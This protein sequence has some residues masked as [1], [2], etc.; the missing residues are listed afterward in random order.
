MTNCLSHTRLIFSLEIPTCKWK[1]SHI[2]IKQDNKT[3]HK[4]EQKYVPHTWSSPFSYVSKWF[5]KPE[6]VFVF[7]LIS[8][9]WYGER[10]WNLPRI[11]ATL[12]PAWLEN[13]LR[14]LIYHL[15]SIVTLYSG[16]VVALLLSV[17]RLRS[18]FR[19]IQT[20]SQI[21]YF[22]GKAQQTLSKF[23]G[24]I[25]ATYTYLNCLF[26]QFL[27]ISR[28]ISVFCDIASIEVTIWQ[29]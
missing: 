4:H 28:Q 9:H 22:S 3:K 7:S 6:N 27:H 13:L 23:I 1:N 21:C 24:I 25:N 18:N 15:T 26:E 14:Y 10:S 19:R 16:T 5:E 20:I 8:Q 2:N 29:L 17:S 12:P 11:I